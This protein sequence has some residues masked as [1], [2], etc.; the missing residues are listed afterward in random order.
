M[1]N[2]YLYI[3][4][5]ETKT[6]YI[7]VTNDL[8]RRVYEH[9][10]K[11]TPGFTAQ[12]EVNH[13]VYFEETNDVTTAINREKQ[14]KG[15]R[16]EKKVALIE[17]SNPHWF[18]LSDRWFDQRPTGGQEVLSPQHQDPSTPPSTAPLRMTAA[19][20]SDRFGK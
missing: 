7:G 8:E 19:R 16:R 2:F 17:K 10:S 18:D 14:L 5:S 13:L 9:K 6:L 20:E 1:Q 3:L 15:W 4:A 11:T 12:Y